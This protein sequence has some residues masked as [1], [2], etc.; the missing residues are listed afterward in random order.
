MPSNL[1]LNVILDYPINESTVQRLYFSNPTKIIH[2]INNEDFKDGLKAVEEEQLKGNY[3]VG[4]LSYD[5]ALTG[6][7]LLFGVFTSPTYVNPATLSL[8]LVKLS[9][10]T[11]SED[12]DRYSEKIQR[13][14]NHIK[15]GDCYQINYTIRANS[16]LISGDALSLYHQLV[17]CQ[18]AKYSAYIEHNHFT[19][20]SFSP[21]LFFTQYQHSIQTKPMKGTKP[22]HDTET[23][24]QQINSLK[25]SSKNQS[26]NVMIVDL[27]RNDLSKIA[28]KGSVKTSNLFMVE[29]YQDILQMTSTISADLLEEISFHHIIE[30]LFPCGSIT[31]APKKKVMEIIGELEDT[32]RGLYCGAIGYLAPNNQSLFNVAIR[33]IIHDKANNQLTYG[34]GSG[35]TYDSDA[36][37]EYEEINNKIRFL[38]QEKPLSLFETVY[39]HHGSCL[40][41]NKHF[42]RL[43]A[44]AKALNFILPNDQ[45]YKSISDLYPAIKDGR[46]RGKFI[47]HKNGI[48]RWE[49]YNLPHHLDHYPVTFAR[50]PI[51]SKDIRINH[52]TTDRSLY[53]ELLD[54]DGQ[55]FD[56]IL[57]NEREEI[58]E[59]TKGNIVIDINGQLLTPPQQSG[60]LPGVLRSHL[61]ENTLIK[62]K[63]LYFDDVINAD[64]LWLI[65]SL[66]GWIQV[67]L[68]I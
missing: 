58:T 54:K 55:F 23:L 4:F 26:E 38:S 20:L 6:Y 62:E 53:D 15:N 49:I 2:A 34:V 50:A 25:E 44:S 51:Q 37:D 19:V 63:V 30:A 3:V 61:L 10:W 14:K 42:D 64:T 66:R 36:F 57:W 40:F 33:T 7:Q 18:A 43:T 11:L 8:P 27:L 60:L 47:Y 52:K 48:A 35:V 45:H 31:G 46:Y 29:P 21:E 39:L 59:F 13:I 5:L 68:A 32:P 1:F 16:E 22:L 67:N 41:W 65:N 24:N 56:V 9:Q 28:K 17:D 12:I